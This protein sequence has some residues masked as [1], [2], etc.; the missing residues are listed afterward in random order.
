MTI[1]K[2][3]GILYR[4]PVDMYLFPC[5]STIVRK[6]ARV[7]RIVIIYADH[8]Y[9]LFIITIVLDDFDDAFASIHCIVLH[10]VLTC[11]HVVVPM[12]SI[13]RECSGVK[14]L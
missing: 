7:I 14:K 8:E 10:D 13:A 3:S 9:I 6:S 2:P 5:P 11:P 12:N 1:R 4:D